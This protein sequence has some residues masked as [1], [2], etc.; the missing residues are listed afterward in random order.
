MEIFKRD[1]IKE[2]DRVLVVS[3]CEKPWAG[4]FIRWEKSKPIVMADKDNREYLVLD[5]VLPI[6]LE[7]FFRELSSKSSWELA[8]K[9]YRFIKCSIEKN[10]EL[11]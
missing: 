1:E 10:N 7:I 9:I 3:S 8:L 4:R 2:N 5:I 6:E 11:R